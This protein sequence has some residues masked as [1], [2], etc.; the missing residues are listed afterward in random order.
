MQLFPKIKLS[1]NLSENHSLLIS[2]A[3]KKEIGILVPKDKRLSFEGTL[4]TEQTCKTCKLTSSNLSFI[5]RKD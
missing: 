2:N 1:V 5:H 4:A 3:F